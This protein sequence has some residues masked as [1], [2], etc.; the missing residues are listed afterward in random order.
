M[1]KETFVRLK[2]RMR[3]LFPGLHHIKLVCFDYIDIYTIREALAPCNKE[4]AA[5]DTDQKEAAQTAAS[6]DPLDD[7]EEEDAESYRQ[8]GTTL[9]LLAR[10]HFLFILCDHYVTKCIGYHRV[11]IGDSFSNGR[12]RVVKKL[13]WGHFSTV[14]QAVDLQASGEG[15]QG[16]PVLCAVKIQKSAEHYREAAYDEIKLL[17]KCSNVGAAG[18]Q[19]SV[20]DGNGRGNGGG[21]LGWGKGTV[22]RV[23]RLLD[24]FEH[25][26]PNGKHVCLV[27]EMLGA[28]MLHTMR[29]R[30]SLHN[31]SN[32]SPVPVADQVTLALP[33]PMV[34]QVAMQVAVV[35]GL[36]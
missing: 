26:G 28:S 21:L 19:N 17:Q 16:A 14:W 22:P 11:Q 30:A 31:N 29:R 12:Y 6:E 15:G 23:V 20:K 33:I 32:S 9:L 27:F 5:G 13:G 7:D 25:N 8:G 1:T 4:E 34:R 3:R 18:A 10:S 2:T 24:W 36:V 35:A